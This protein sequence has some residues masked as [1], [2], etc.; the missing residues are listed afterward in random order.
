MPGVIVSEEKLVA[1]IV[2][3][4]KQP[5]ILNILT[6]IQFIPDPGM[7]IP[8][9]GMFIPDPGMFIPDPGSDFF[10]FRIPD[11]D[12]NCSH[13]GSASKNLSILTQ[14]VVSKL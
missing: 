5:K 11:P 8:D 4:G 10:P 7:F 1:G 13:P 9:P 12:P 2:D 3:S 14:K 6:K